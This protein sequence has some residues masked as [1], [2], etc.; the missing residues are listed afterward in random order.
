MNK[1]IEFRNHIYDINNHYVY[2]L[3]FLNNY[4][5]TNK[6]TNPK[7]IALIERIQ[8]LKKIECKNTLGDKDIGELCKFLGD[9]PY[10]DRF[11]VDTILKFLNSDIKKMLANNIKTLIAQKTYNADK[12]YHILDICIECQMDLLAG[13]DIIFFL[14]QYNKDLDILSILLDYLNI[15]KRD[16]FKNDLYAL[17]ELDYPDNIKFQILNLLVNLYSIKNIDMYFIKDKIRHGKN[18]V[19]YDSYIQFLNSDLTFKKDGV[20]ILQSMFYGDF[21]DSG[22]GNN[23]GLAV[24]LKDLGD[25]VSKDKDISFVFTVTITQ[26][27]NKP[28]ISTYGENHVFIRLPIYLDKSIDDPF[29]KKELFIKRYIANFLKQVDVKPDIFHTRYLDNASKAVADLSKE[30]NKKLVFTLAPDPHRNMFD[31]FGY[32]KELEFKDL[33]IKLN[34]I[35]IGDELIH[36]SD[37]IVGIGD[38]DIKKEL[39]IYFP[40]FKNDSINRKLTMIGE[41][42]QI[43]KSSRSVNLDLYLNEF[44][45]SNNIKESFF[46]KPIILNVGRLADQKGHIELLKAWTN[47]RLSKTHNLLIIGGD[48]ESPSKEEESIIRFFYDY[49]EK[50]SDLK[51]NFIHK[52]A[53]PNNQVRLLEK[54]ILKKEFNLPHIYLCSSI[55]EEFGIAILE[56]MSKGFLTFGPVKGGVKSYLKSGINGFLIDTSSWETIGKE[57]EKYIFDSGF[58]NKDFNKI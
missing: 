44:I 7:E 29:I 43:N 17:L 36:I 49:I 53:M 41:G 10:T 18:K 16:G 26:K 47:S 57:A 3:I 21:E 5:K 9:N 13:D 28:F 34:K 35:K 42:I 2:P 48:I 14:E 52:S 11:I 58:T 33:I 39:E 19:F 38:E 1:F 40:Q 32:L 31:E 12:L 25:E 20:L 24:L 30:L 4:I 55:K 51:D 23:G 45:K 54:S 22:K 8:I 56:A 15:F 50:H 6:T 27:S 46:E 37:R